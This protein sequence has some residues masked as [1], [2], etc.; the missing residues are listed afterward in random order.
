MSKS[1][2]YLLGLIQPE[3][4]SNSF[5]R[6]K[7]YHRLQLLK[8]FY[9][10]HPMV[11]QGI[12]YLCSAYFPEKLKINLP[13]LVPGLVE[14]KEVNLPDYYSTEDC[15]EIN[16]IFGFKIHNQTLTLAKLE[17]GYHQN[18]HVQ[19]A[20]DWYYRL[21]WSH[22]KSKEAY[23]SNNVEELTNRGDELLYERNN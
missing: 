10:E 23:L 8:L 17:T 22:F 6:E 13:A 5:E 12:D 9:S 21:L 20:K 7:L 16:R 14:Q 1:I 18:E 15:L 19:K 2:D 4:L 11:M 3:T